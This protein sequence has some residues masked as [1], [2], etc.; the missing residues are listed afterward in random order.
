MVNSALGTQNP[1]EIREGS[2]EK[3][4]FELPAKMRRQLHVWGRG[5]KMG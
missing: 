2:A 5:A 1:L 3:V 4:A